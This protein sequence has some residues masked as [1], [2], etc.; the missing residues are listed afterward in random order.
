MKILAENKS[1]FFNFEI[2]EKFEAGIS[3]LGQEVKSLKTNRID[4]SKSAIVF[5]MGKKKNPEAFWVG[6]RIPPYQPRN[7]PYFKEDRDRKILL[8]KSEIK[9]LLGKTKQRGFFL[10]PLKLYTKR[11][12]IKMEIGL[13]KRKKKVQKKAKLKEKD[14]KRQLEREIK[15][16]FR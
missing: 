5:K 15:E 14:L 6:A 4:L 9:Y 16:Y 8:K 2:L 12:W 10:I 1:A 11:G 3:L 13:G 7:P